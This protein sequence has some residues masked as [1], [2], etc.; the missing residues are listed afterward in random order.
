MSLFSIMNQTQAEASGLN[1]S[2][3]SCKMGARALSFLW[4]HHEALA[5]EGIE[6][7]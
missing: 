1:L 3:I 6:Q 7:V 5:V 2:L 4:C